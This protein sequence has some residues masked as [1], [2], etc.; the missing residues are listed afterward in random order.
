MQQIRMKNLTNSGSA[1]GGGGGEIL[2]KIPFL[3]GESKTSTS[4]LFKSC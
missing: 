2:Y 1:L 3:Q 4:G